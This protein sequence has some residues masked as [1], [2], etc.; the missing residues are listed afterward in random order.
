MNLP[1]LKLVARGGT[2]HTADTVSLDG[3]EI[4][5]LTEISLRLAV[6][7]VNEAT[8]TVRLGD[9][10]VDTQTLTALAAYIKPSKEDEEDGAESKE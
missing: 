1:T 10:D 3:W 9:V 5:G 2:L 4:P 8:F 7:M 6:G